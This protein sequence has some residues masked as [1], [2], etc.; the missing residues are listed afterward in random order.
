MMDLFIVSIL[1]LVGVVLLLAEMFFLPGIGLAGVGGVVCSMGAIAWAYMYISV[2]AG[3]ITLLVCAI[4]AV[5]FAIVFFKSRAVEKM[6]LD[7]EIDGS[8]QMP[9]AGKHMKEMQEVKE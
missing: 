8:V 2:K 4:L 9:E 3:T 5:V 7:T 6:G 1:V